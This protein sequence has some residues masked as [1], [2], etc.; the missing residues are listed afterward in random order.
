MDKIVDTDVTVF[1][2]ILFFVVIYPFNKYILDLNIKIDLILKS[3]VLSSQNY[4]IS[5]T[6][7]N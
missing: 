1:L 5:K 2:F 6:L 7:V 4:I 3:L